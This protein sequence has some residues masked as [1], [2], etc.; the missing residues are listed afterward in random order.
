VNPDAAPTLDAATQ[1]SI[2]GSQLITYNPFLRDG[3]RPKYRSSPKREAGSSDAS[4]S[5]GRRNRHG[6]SA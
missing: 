3:E 6:L 1:R 2:D 4:A 5:G